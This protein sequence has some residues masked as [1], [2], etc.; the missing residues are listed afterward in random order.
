MNESC[1]LDRP[2]EILLVEDNSDDVLLAKHAFSKVELPHKLHVVQ[3]G[4][5]ALSF[6]RQQGNYQTARHPDLVLL[7]LNMP[8]TDGR[9]VLKQLKED[10]NLRRIPVV[11]L[12]TSNSSV[13]LVLTYSSHANAYLV[14]PLELDQLEKLVD[15]LM[16]FWFRLVTHPP[17]LGEQ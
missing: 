8:G 2:A 3:D 16:H 11:I 10:A 12:T 9:E 15:G 14:K 1:T 6:L 13:D 7:D 17:K 5:E 4:E